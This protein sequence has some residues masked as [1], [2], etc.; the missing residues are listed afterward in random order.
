MEVSIV[1]CCFDS[2]MT[3]AKLQKMI[4]PVQERL[5]ILSPARLLS[6][7]MQRSTSFLSGGGILG[8]IASSSVQSKVGKAVRSVSG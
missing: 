2:Q 7:I 1:A 4:N 5:V 6:T 8:G 3:G